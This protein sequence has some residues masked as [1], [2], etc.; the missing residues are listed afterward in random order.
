MRTRFYIE[1]TIPS[2]YHTTRT[3]PESVARMN[4]T[5]QWWSKYAHYVELPALGQSVRQVR[6]QIS[7]ERGHD[8]DRVVA[9]YQA[10][11]EE[12]KRSGEFRFARVSG[13]PTRRSDFT[14]P[15]SPQGV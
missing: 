11:E 6:H 9:Y 12:L 5:R 4:W 15:L 14:H 8:V 7:A 10:V 2:F 13:G 1:T 3:D